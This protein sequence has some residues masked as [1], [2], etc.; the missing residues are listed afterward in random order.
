MFR[1]TSAEVSESVAPMCRALARTL[2]WS[3]GTSFGREVV[4]LLQAELPR[5]TTVEQRRRLQAAIDQIAHS[6]VASER[7]REVRALALLDQQRTDAARAELKRLAA[8]HSDA[9]LTRAA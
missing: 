9:A 2:R 8:G 3:R 4:P 6:P 7:L 5:T 1:H